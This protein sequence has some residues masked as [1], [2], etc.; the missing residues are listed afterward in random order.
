MRSR[1]SEHRSQSGRRAGT[2]A[3]HLYHPLQAD[4][5]A[6]QLVVLVPV[7]TCTAADRRAG[8]AG[9]P[10]TRQTNLAAPLAG[11]GGSENTGGSSSS[12]GKSSTAAPARW[13]QPVRRR[14]SSR[15]RAWAAGLAR[16]SPHGAPFI[17][18]ACPLCSSC[19][20]LTSAWRNPTCS[21][22]MGRGSSSGG[23]RHEVHDHPN[24]AGGG[25]APQGHR[26]SAPGPSTAEPSTGCTESQWHVP[27]SQ[28]PPAAHLARLPL[29]H[30]PAASLAAAAARQRQQQQVEVRL[31]RRPE[32]ERGGAAWQAQHVERELQVGVR[33]YVCVCA[34]VC[35][36]VVVVGVQG[37]VCRFPSRPAPA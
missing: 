22:S 27:A 30:S 4:S 19:R 34:C 12:H 36:W 29:Q 16:I 13:E 11:A 1:S 26:T 5:L 25:P 33:W 2:A 31:L 3:L 10:A 28:P 20:P 9:V 7:H 8:A 24:D 35:A 14:Q 21:S 15:R 37:P 32:A 23:G 18:T 6:A 17:I